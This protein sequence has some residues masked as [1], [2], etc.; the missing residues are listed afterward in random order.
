MVTLVAQN[1]FNGKPTED[2]INI[3]KKNPE[4]YDNAKKYAKTAFK[5]IKKLNALFK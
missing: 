3:L 5:S 1:D 4:S 2:I